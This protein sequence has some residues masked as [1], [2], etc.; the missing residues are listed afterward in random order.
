M[1]LRLRKWEIGDVDNLTKYGDNRK[2]WNHLADAFPSP[3][4]RNDAI[5]FIEKVNSISPNKVLAI[6][7]HNEAIGSIGIFPD[8]DIHRKNAAIA[9]WIA[10]PFWGKGIATE[11]VRLMVDYGFDSFDIERIYAK[12][13]GFNLASHRVLEKVGFTKTAVIKDGVFK[14]DEYH[15]EYIFSLT[16]ASRQ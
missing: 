12:P 1:K 8:T 2:I 4:T 15:D 5:E 14:N 6:E 3:F 16:K 11:A 9:Y 10:E 13:F 7:Y